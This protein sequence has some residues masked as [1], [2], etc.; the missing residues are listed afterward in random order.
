[1]FIIDSFI[2]QVYLI[3]A[4]TLIYY[5]FVLVVMPLEGKFLNYM[6]IFNE[7]CISLAMPFLLMFT[8]QDG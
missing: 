2:T 8:E 7:T 4:S 5:A 1:V 3:W 6:E